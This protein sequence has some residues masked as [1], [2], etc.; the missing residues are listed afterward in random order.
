MS[1]KKAFDE[2]KVLRAALN[3]FRQ[4]G[5]AGA[6]LSELEEATGLNRS[7]LYNA[8]GNK[9]GLFLR[10]MALFRTVFSQSALNQL[11][12]PTFRQS[13]EDFFE[14]SGAFAMPNFPGGCVASLASLEMGGRGGKIAEELD[15]GINGMIDAVRE[16]CLQAVAD[17]ELPKDTNC[18]DLAALIIATTRGVSVICMATQ[19]STAGRGAY[20]ALIQTICGPN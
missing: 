4:R 19:D 13:L 3:V 6:G 5:F 15:R 14:V 12:K 7:S 11:N 8:F 2:D 9:E 20:R 10:S 18:D 16:R 1:G 17:G